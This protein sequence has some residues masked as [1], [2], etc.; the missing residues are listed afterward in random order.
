MAIPDL[1]LNWEQQTV[2]IKRLTR[3]HLVFMAK[4]KNNSLNII[5]STNPLD[6]TFGTGRVLKESQFLDSIRSNPKTQIVPVASSQLNIDSA[7]E[8]FSDHY[9]IVCSP[10]NIHNST[11]GVIL[12]L[13]NNNNLINQNPKETI[14]AFN[15]TITDEL[16]QNKALFKKKANISDF[17]FVPDKVENILKSTNA[18]LSITDAN[19]NIVFHSHIDVNSIHS[20]C[21][22][23]F[24]NRN[25]I[26]D[27]CPRKPENSSHTTFT[28]ET[29]NGEKTYQITTMPVVGDNKELFLAEVRVD[30]TPRVVAE[31]KIREL[32]ELLEFSM[33]VGKIAFL[34]YNFEKDIINTNSYFEKI[35][36]YNFKHTRVNFQWIISRIHPEDSKRVKYMFFRRKNKISTKLNF[37]FRLLNAGNKYLWLRYSG[38][39]TEL[40]S[41]SYPSRIS[42]IINDITDLKSA[43]S[44]LIKEQKKTIKNSQAQSLFM[45]NISH[46]IRTPMNAILGFSD[47]LSTHILKPPYNSYLESIKSSG[48][49]LLSLINDLLDFEKVQANKMFLKKDYVNFDIIVSEIK[50]AFLMLA[51]ENEDTINVIK[52]NDFPESICIDATKIR[53]ILL[54][55]VNNALK[56]TNKGNVTIEY[57]FQKYEN[58]QS[59]NFAFSIKDTGIGI[60]MEKQK[61][62]FE[63]FMQD[64]QTQKEGN[65]G[66]GLG[67]S[68]VQKYVEM[69]KGSITLDSYENKGSKFTILIPDIEFTSKEYYKTF[70]DEIKLFNKES[71]LI[72]SKTGSN[73]EVLKSF[74]FDMNLTCQ[75]INLDQKEINIKDKPKIIIASPDNTSDLKLINIL[76]TEY[77]LK[78]TPLLLMDSIQISQSYTERICVNDYIDIPINKKLLNSTLLKYLHSDSLSTKNEANFQKT[79]F[80]PQEKED[81]KEKFKTNIIPV[82]NELNEI[83]SSHNLKKLSS[84]LKIISKTVHWPSLNNYLHHLE[85][86]IKSY[87]FESIQN[88]LKSFNQLLEDMD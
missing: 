19:A 10:I 43:L 18:T 6:I 1:K 12:L 67:L 84:E 16:N 14:D 63:P 24:R 66:T 3:A 37:E 38:K 17:H 40:D 49:L 27:E 60:K 5:A 87:D 46:E 70:E 39:I 55:L 78:E 57:S 81:L 26:C 86:G 13:I 59:G 68:I 35:T 61:E 79:P 4:L 54:N 51:N 53:Q 77:K 62:I 28:Y 47:L 42:G 41:N 88:L 52:P 8:E 32:K 73:L 76:I 72:I 50:Q 80:T 9:S 22:K 20:P 75:V 58:R 48:N 74:C 7:F 69:M 44:N 2:L 30:I 34:E 82:C 65:P 11:W 23:Y 25:E 45:A 15:K 36:G 64:I 83:L 29:S 21:Y 33:N 85:N 71:I 56:F 31:K